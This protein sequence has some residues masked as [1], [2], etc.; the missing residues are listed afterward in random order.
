MELTTIR[1]SPMDTLML[2]HDFYKR[3]CGFSTRQ[4]GIKHECLR[5]FLHFSPPTPEDKQTWNRQSVN[6]QQIVCGSEEGRR[7]GKKKKK[8]SYN[9][10][11]KNKKEKRKKERKKVAKGKLQKKTALLFPSRSLTVLCYDILTGSQVQQAR[12]AGVIAL[13]M[14]ATEGLS[15][16]TTGASKPAVLNVHT[17][18]TQDV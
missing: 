15:H 17:H 4:L 8:E 6:Y 2:L 11:T 12:D 5:S 9:G 7:G 1:G 13:P 3:Y 14:S 16:V 10:A 18:G